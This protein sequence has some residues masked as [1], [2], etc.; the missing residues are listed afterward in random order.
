MSSELMYHLETT[1]S[2]VLMILTVTQEIH[3]I[4]I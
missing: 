4:F 3:M 2:G 1:K